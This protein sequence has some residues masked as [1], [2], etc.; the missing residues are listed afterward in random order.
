M[1]APLLRKAGLTSPAGATSEDAN[2]TLMT[3]PTKE[4]SYDSAQPHPAPV[5]TLVVAQTYAKSG[6]Y[7]RLNLSGGF[8]RRLRPRRH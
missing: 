6:R 8:T 4:L 2:T 7:H 1:A 5:Q 3:A